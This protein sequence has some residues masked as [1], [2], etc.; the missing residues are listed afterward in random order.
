LRDIDDGK[1]CPSSRLFRLPRGSTDYDN[2]R[3]AVP[4]SVHD[5]LGRHRCARRAALRN[6]Q[7]VFSIVLEA[8]ETGSGANNT[9]LVCSVCSMPPAN[10]GSMHRLLQARPASSTCTLTLAGSKMPACG[11]SPAREAQLSQAHLAGGR[12]HHFDDAAGNSSGSAVPERQANQ[13]GKTLVQWLELPD[14][15]ERCK[16]L[17]VAGVAHCVA[18]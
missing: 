6:E 15:C 8:E 2:P 3:C 5:R 10:A 1:E 17:A 16:R 12:G 9:G 11:S 7:H 14:S 13:G 18:A 4:L